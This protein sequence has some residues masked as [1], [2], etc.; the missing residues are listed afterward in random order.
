M[1]ITGMLEV[2]LLL[3]SCLVMV[4]P[5]DLSQSRRI[6]DLSQS[7]ICASFSKSGRGMSVGGRASWQGMEGAIL[8]PVACVGM[9][10]KP[11]PTQRGREGEWGSADSPVQHCTGRADAPRERVLRLAGGGY[12]RKDR[13]ISRPSLPPAHTSP[14]PPSFGMGWFVQARC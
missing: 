3:W 13:C 10:W 6:S 1:L 11:A 12:T 7:R 14:V 9:F 4:L 2:T 8:P 5:A